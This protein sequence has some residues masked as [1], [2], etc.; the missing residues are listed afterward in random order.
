MLTRK[1]D[2]RHRGHD[3][4]W[5]CKRCRRL[6]G[7]E[8]VRCGNK[9]RRLAGVGLLLGDSLLA[10]CRRRRLISV[11]VWMRE[12]E[13][14][15]GSAACMRDRRAAGLGCVCVRETPLKRK[16]VPY[17]GQATDLYRAWLV[18]CPGSAWATGY[19]I[20]IFSSSSVGWSSHLAQLVRKK[21]R[22]C[23]LQVG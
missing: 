15:R 20:F 17:V 3:R 11:D 21:P 9:D 19:S 12:P 2:S 1:C 16:V 10:T 22:G 14:C 5:T 8:R 7:R 18:N 23:I 13:F 6:D 4:S